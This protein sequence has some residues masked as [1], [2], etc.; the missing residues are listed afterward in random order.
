MSAKLWCAGS[1]AYLGTLEGHRDSIRSVASAAD[2]RLATGSFVCTAKIW[3]T[4]AAACL[5]TLEGHRYAVCSAT[6]TADRRFAT[7]SCDAFEVLER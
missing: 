6:F 2:G 5:V 3:S 4:D 7:G 1:T